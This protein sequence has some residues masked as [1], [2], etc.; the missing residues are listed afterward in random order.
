MANSR[1]KFEIEISD[2]R[3]VNLLQNG[4]TCAPRINRL[5]KLMG[6]S[7]STV[8]SKV[9]KLEAIGIVRGYSAIVDEEKL[10]IKQTIFALVRVKPE[11]NSEDIP[12]LLAFAHPA[13][14]EAF[15][16]SGGYDVL[17]KIRVKSIEEYVRSV[18]PA[19]IEVGK[20]KIS[21]ILTLISTE[22]IK[23]DWR[24]KL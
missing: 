22:K 23:E 24:V 18:K 3:L 2:M 13:V 20:D 16:I 21:E 5:A 4:E 15:Q 7:V 10:G 8:H 14:Q 1:K 6:Y 12:K 9:K 17:L 19:I 11:K